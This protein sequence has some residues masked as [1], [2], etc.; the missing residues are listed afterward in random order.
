MES[1]NWRFI[2]KTPSEY[3]LAIFPFMASLIDF[4]SYLDI[5]LLNS[6]LGLFKSYFFVSIYKWLVYESSAI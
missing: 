1:W 3:L 2:Q 5:F 6:L 4:T